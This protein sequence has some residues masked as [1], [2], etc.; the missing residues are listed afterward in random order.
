MNKQELVEFVA[1][2]AG[3]TKAAAAAS[4]DACFEAVAGAL[5]RG[6]EVRIPN[7]GTWYVAKRGASVGRN[8]QTGKEIKI[9]AR[10]QPKFRAGK[11]LKLVVNK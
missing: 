4:I 6:G 7:F 8:P 10:K 9:P 5:K 3:S 1:K 2:K 11:G